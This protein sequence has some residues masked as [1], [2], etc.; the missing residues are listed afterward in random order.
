MTPISAAFDN[1]RLIRRKLRI[2]H[3]T[4]ARE[5]IG[6]NRDAAVMR[7]KDLTDDLIRALQDFADM[8]YEEEVSLVLKGLKGEQNL[9]RM[10]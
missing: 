8:G 3:E 2:E 5:P 4:I 1:V 9:R 6:P 10:N 7:A